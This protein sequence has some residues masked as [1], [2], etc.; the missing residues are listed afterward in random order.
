MKI[1]K[2]R[3]GLGTLLG[4]GG[5]AMVSCTSAGKQFATDMFYTG[6]GTGV[7]ESV[8]KEVW[9]QNNSNSHQRGPVQD[10]F[11]VV[12]KATGEGKTIFGDEWR[13]Y[14]EN[15]IQKEKYPKGYKIYIY[16]KGFLISTLE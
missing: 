3:K 14:A 4:I 7:H 10:Y 5:L 9:N 6:V 16:E 8:A 12:N 2:M 13:A 11:I 15:H 1:M